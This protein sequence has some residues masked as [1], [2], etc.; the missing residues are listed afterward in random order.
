MH[1]F[2]VIPFTIKMGFRDTIPYLMGGIKALLD[3]PLVN[4]PYAFTSSTGRS[5]VSN[6]PVLYNALWEY[7]TKSPEVLI[8]IHTIISDVISDGYT[9]EPYEGGASE[10]KVQDARN[11][12]RRSRFET[13]I[14][15]P[16]LWDG[17]VTGDNYLHMPQ[18]SEDEV[19]QKIDDIVTKYGFYDKRRM[20]NKIYQRF[21]M[22]YTFGSFD[23]IPLASETMTI[24]HDIH[25]NVEKYVQRV[26]SNEARFDPSEVIHNKYITMNG[27]VYGFTPMKAILSEL[28]ILAM[29]KDIIGH[30]FENGGIPEKL[31]IMEEE[32][33]KSPNVKNLAHQLRRFKQLENKQRS[34]LLTGKV[35]VE[36]L[37]VNMKDM[38]FKELIDVMSKIVMMVWGVPPAKMGMVGEKG[39]G[40]D[41]GLATEGYYKK[42]SN[43]QTWFYEP[44]NWELLIPK[45]GVQMIPNRAYLQDEVR[46]TQVLSQKVQAAVT[47]YQN[48]WIN[49]KYITD[50]LL[51]IPIQYR[52]DF[53]PRMVSGSQPQTQ[54]QI[55][56]DVVMNDPAKQAVNESRR[57]KQ[58]M[59]AGEEND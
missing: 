54:N 4:E 57:S 58:K 20:A 33:P 13:V 34:L 36:E 6:S 43:L 27:K 51:K 21:L 5:Q 3:K 11:W 49:E 7:A 45:F 18:V 48:G 10:K 2:R 59:N 24:K 40:Y 47:M 55:G 26:G 17:L 37:S 46:E 12:L 39:S 22:D 50:H 35:K 28:S 1:F 30:G 31:F 44:I 23:L 52:G 42:V 38:P 53:K 19:H 15:P 29:S 8:P 41:S 56:D 32:S 9:L 16:L 25:Q 14:A